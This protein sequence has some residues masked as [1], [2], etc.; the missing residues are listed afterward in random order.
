MELK[1]IFLKRKFYTEILKSTVLKFEDQKSTF[2][3]SKKCS[4]LL[5]FYQIVS[6]KDLKKLDHSE[7]KFI[8]N[9]FDIKYPTMDYRELSEHKTFNRTCRNLLTRLKS[10]N[11]PSLANHII[12]HS[13]NYPLLRSFHFFS[14]LSFCF[15]EKWEFPLEVVV[16]EAIQ[17]FMLIF[18]ANYFKHVITMERK[19][20]FF[21][22]FLYLR[23]PFTALAVHASPI[24]DSHFFN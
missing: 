24:V 13:R 4:F 22:V 20:E 11:Q 23:W 16:E 17:P 21:R 5:T 6:R 10:P 14:I 9:D 3:I 2:F 18:I 1:E 15:G 7:K 19:W 8:T 12:F